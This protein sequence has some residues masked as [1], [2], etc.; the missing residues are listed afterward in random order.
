MGTNIHQGMLAD[1]DPD[2]QALLSG[3]PAKTETP[4]AAAADTDD[5]GEPITGNVAGDASV[6]EGEA[7]KNE[8]A[9]SA[10]K[11]D[12]AAPTAD[13]AAAALAEMTPEPAASPATPKAF[14]VPGDDF[15]AKR[16]ELQTQRKDIIKQWGDGEL[17]DEQYAAKL[18]ELDGQIYTVIQQQAKAQTLAEIN[19]QNRRDAEAKQQQAENAVMVKVAAASKAAGQIDYGTDGD[20]CKAFDAA[21]MA[22]KAD[23]KNADLSLDKVAERAHR[24]VLAM[25]GVEVATP[26]STAPTAA[27]TPAKPKPAVPPVTLGTMPAAAAN[28]TGDS[29]DETF[30]AIEDPDEREAKW[31]ALSASQ[32][33]QML[34]RTVP[35][36]RGRH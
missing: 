32:R 26:A 23:P 28:A 36:T 21:F 14:E 6:E 33:Q 10:E 15:D 9:A 11:E 30:D 17:S 29:F 18:D 13:E 27:A 8:Q 31:A 12:A 5:D 34:R 19:E 16:K 1:M 22:A 3:Q 7:A 2:E 20:A 24:A 35:T 4:A 25:R